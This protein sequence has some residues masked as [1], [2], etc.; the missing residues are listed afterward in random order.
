MRRVE[1]PPDPTAGDLGLVGPKWRGRPGK[2]FCPGLTPLPYR[3]VPL[4][5]AVLLP[6]DR[7]NDTQSHPNG[8]DDDT[9]G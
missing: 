8:C 3:T 7:R 5:R 6:K 9:P 2:P 4:Q 1:R